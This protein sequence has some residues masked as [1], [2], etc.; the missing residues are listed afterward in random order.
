MA[1]AEIRRTSAHFMLIYTPHHKHTCAEC[2]EILRGMRGGLRTDRR[3]AGMRRCLPSLRRELPADGGLNAARIAGGPMDF[4]N[5]HILPYLITLAMTQRDIS[6]YRR[7]V[8]PAAS[9][10]VLEV[11][12]GSGL[13]LPFYG[14]GVEQIFGLPVAATIADTDGDG[15]LAFE[16]VM[17]VHKRIFDKVDSNKDGKVTME[18]IQTFFRE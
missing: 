17:A 15:T 10:Q 14:P 12:I 4:Y 8:V 1:C 6:E 2:A 7:R 16:E 5:E 11:G 3:H 18:E 13:N 9:G